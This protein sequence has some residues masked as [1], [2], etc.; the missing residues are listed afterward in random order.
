MGLQ[1][2]LRPLSG[3][4][5]LAI[6]MTTLI[7]AALFL[8]ARRKL[9]D[10][11]DRRFNRR[12]YDA[13]RTVDAF[14]ARLREQIELDTLRYELLAVIDET[15]AP[16]RASLW[17]RRSE[18]GYERR[19]CC[20]WSASRRCPQRSCSCWLLVLFVDATAPDLNLKTA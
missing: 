19:R 18:H 5:D 11:V 4:S 14:S 3:G 7:V 10:V 12:D 17:L 2:L 13:A 20:A 1:E 8:P 15:M 6:V 16:D 9:Q